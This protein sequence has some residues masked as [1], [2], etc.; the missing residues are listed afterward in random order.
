M[1]PSLRLFVTAVEKELIQERKRK[2]RKRNNRF[3]KQT[4]TRAFVVFSD[5]GALVSSGV[6]GSQKKQLPPRLC[7]FI[8]QLVDGTF[9][10]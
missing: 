8:N 7:M 2:Q 1:S 4:E 5:F 6:K 3:R 10:V 9:P